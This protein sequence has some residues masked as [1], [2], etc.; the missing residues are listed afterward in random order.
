MKHPLGKR[1]EVIQGYVK[2][3][4]S[5]QTAANFLGCS[6]RTI[7]RHT[8]A[9]I[10]NGTSGLKDNRH[11]NNHKLT[12]EQRDKVVALKQ[13]DRWRSGRNIRDKLKLAVHRRTINAIFQKA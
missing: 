3:D 11:S 5:K 13:K 1:I 7:E 2:G 4:I 8:N 10:I 9:F 6:F 12:P